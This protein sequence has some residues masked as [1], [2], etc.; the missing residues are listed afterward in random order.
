MNMVFLKPV[1]PSGAAILAKNTRK[2]LK[3]PEAPNEMDPLFY[4]KLFHTFDVNKSEKLLKRCFSC[5]K[6]ILQKCIH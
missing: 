5:G 1:S 4:V 2:A 6:I 3:N